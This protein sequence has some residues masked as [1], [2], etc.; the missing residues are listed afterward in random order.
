MLN[1]KFRFLKI[2]CY[3]YVLLMLSSCTT[4]LVNVG[5]V[6]GGAVIINTARKDQTIGS[7]LDDTV[8]A[9]KIK[10]NFINRQFQALYTK[11]YIRVIR[12]RVF[13]CGFVSS[14]NDIL[15]AVNIAKN[16]AG[17]V[18]VINEIKITENSNETDFKQYAIDAGITSLVKT[19]LLLAKS[20][21]S[22]NYEVFTHYNIV[23]IFGLALSGEEMDEV[24]DIISKINDVEEV[25]SYI[26]VSNDN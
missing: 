23:Y 18:D 20:V 24:T 22:S 7:I 12:G 9:S 2:F 19:K 5:I 25:V 11:I 4:A 14:E 17:V 8:I 10:K 16:Q 15:V 13:L 3:L 21:K 6:G 1:N 26:S